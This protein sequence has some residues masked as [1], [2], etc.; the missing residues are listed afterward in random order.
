MIKA[1]AFKEW[2][3]MRSAFWGLLGLWLI[4]I[5]YIYIDI[6][7]NLKFFEA[8]VLWYNITVLGYI[9]YRFIFYIPLLTG[10]ILGIT[11][12]VP[13]ISEKRLKLTLH[14]PVNEGKMLLAMSSIG[15][16][17]LLIIYLVSIL[18]LILV[19]SNYFPKEI[20]YSMLKTIAPWYLAGLVLYFSTSMIILEPIWKRRLLYTPIVLGFVF[21]LLIEGYYNLYEYSIYKFA[22]FAVFFFFGVLITGYRFKRGATK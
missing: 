10:L 2:L 7:Y 5:I 3:K 16:F 13:E 17:L 1:V 8:S 4:V 15:T 21:M 12:Y 9:F 18:L 19:S 11:Q 14:L 20:T 6:S 22:I